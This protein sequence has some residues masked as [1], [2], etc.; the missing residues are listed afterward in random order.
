[1]PSS[2][3]LPTISKFLNFSVVSNSVASNDDTM[4]FEN[5]KRTH[6]FIALFGIDVTFEMRTVRFTNVF[7]LLIP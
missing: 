7:I 4:Q 6:N 1:M 5:A 3:G 2:A